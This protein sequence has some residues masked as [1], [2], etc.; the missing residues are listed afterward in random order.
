M[1]QKTTYLQPFFPTNTRKGNFIHPESPAMFI[2]LVS[3]NKYE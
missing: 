2:N 3:K 1:G